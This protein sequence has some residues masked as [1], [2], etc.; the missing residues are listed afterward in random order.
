MIIFICIEEYGMYS[1]PT[2]KGTEVPVIRSIGCRIFIPPRLLK[3]LDISSAFK[4]WLVEKVVD[5][6]GRNVPR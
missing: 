6:P 2:T 4:I 5:S 3:D 1:S